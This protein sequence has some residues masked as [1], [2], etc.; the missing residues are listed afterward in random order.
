M[1]IVDS[2]FTN[3]NANPKVTNAYQ[4]VIDIWFNGPTAIVTPVPEDSSYFE[5]IKPKV[6]SSEYRY[7]GIN[8]NSIAPITKLVNLLTERKL[9]HPRSVKLSPVIKYLPKHFEPTG[10]ELHPV[11]GIQVW[12]LKA[13]LQDDANV[14]LL[15]RTMWEG[16]YNQDFKVDGQPSFFY[17]VEKYPVFKGYFNN[18]SIKSTTY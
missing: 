9:I 3:E 17:C 16:L 15:E 14:E 12:E 5:A 4:L 11:F 1:G 10:L 6:K 2:Q 13:I 8:Q 18:G 7:P